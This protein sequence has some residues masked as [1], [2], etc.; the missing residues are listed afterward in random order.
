[1]PRRSWTMLM[2]FLRSS[3]WVSLD[4][5]SPV[6]LSQKGIALFL[7]SSGRRKGDLSQ[8]FGFLYKDQKSSIEWGWGFLRKKGIRPVSAPLSF[9]QSVD[10]KKRGRFSSVSIRG[11]I[12]YMYRSQEWLYK[13][14]PEFWPLGLFTCPRDS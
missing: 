8:F 5:A 9:F 6:R 12:S 2:K 7:L 3:Y 10:V 1:M 14:S 11:Y 13:V 4:P